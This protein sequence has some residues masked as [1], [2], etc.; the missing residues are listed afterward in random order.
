MR[1]ENPG[2]TP[3]HLDLWHGFLVMPVARPSTLR[4]VVLVL[5]S[6]EAAFLLAFLLM[7]LRGAETSDPIGRSIATGMAQITAIPLAALVA[8][9]I[10]LGYVGRA[11]PLALGLLVLALPISAM[12]WLFA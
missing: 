8:P 12:L 3:H 7:M 4:R 9:A 2:Q 1:K 10:T 11:L 5:G 6:I